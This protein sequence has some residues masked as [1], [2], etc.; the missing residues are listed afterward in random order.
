MCAQLI[1]MAKGWR[2]KEDGSKIYVT[3]R[4]GKRI[5][6]S[7]RDAFALASADERPETKAPKKR[8]LDPVPALQP[9]TVMEPSIEKYFKK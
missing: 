9:D 7:G 2:T 4:N 3:F 8:K 1:K 5:E 6:A